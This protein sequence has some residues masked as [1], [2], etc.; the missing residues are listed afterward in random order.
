MLK[1]EKSWNVFGVLLGLVVFIVGV[2][3]VGKDLPTFETD[4]TRYASFGADFYTYQYEATRAAATNT[5]AVAEQLEALR[6]EAN[7]YFSISLMIA[8]AFIVLS[9]GKKLCL[10]ENANIAARIDDQPMVEVHSDK[11]RE[12]EQ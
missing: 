12:E 11:N 7:R 6:N 2:V 4:S 1:R 10:A 3:F 9:Y 5:E 8:G